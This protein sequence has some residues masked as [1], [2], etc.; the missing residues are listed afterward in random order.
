M[1]MSIVRDH[2]CDVARARASLELDGELREFDLR[3]L[4]RHLAGCHECRSFVAEMGAVTA[5]VREAPLVRHSCGPV[6]RQPTRLLRVRRVAPLVAALVLVSTAAS[7]FVARETTR[8]PVRPEL[9]STTF[10]APIA[11]ADQFSSTRRGRTRIKLPIGQRSA[12]TEFEPTHPT[13]TS[14]RRIPQ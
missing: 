13:V 14:V 5:K 11:V 10:L 7:S 8:R 2:A 12:L 3:L 9:S 1:Q 6:G 4:E